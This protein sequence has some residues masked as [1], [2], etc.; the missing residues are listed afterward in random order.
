MGSLIY[1]SPQ[2]RENPHAAQ[3]TDDV[4]ALGQT[5]Y[6]VLSGHSPHGGIEGLS[7][8]GYPVWID[9]WVRALRNPDA[10]R[11]PQ[12]AIECLTKWNGMS[13]DIGAL[14]KKLPR[15]VR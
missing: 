2:Q 11:R 3:F 15:G 6:H 12:S 14:L 13:I 8:L 5:A 7:E 4:F 1:I 9:T 10:S